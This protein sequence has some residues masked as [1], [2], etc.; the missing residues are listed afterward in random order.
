LPYYENVFLVRPDVSSQQ[1][2]TLAQSFSDLLASKGGAVAKVEHWGLRNLT[3]RIK[4]NRKAHYVLLGID[5]PPGAI[6]ELENTLRMSE[7]VLRSLTVRV[8]ALEEGP[9]AMMR[10]KSRDDRPRRDRRGRGPGERDVKPA[11]EAV[12]TKAPDDP[13]EASGTADTDAGKPAEAKG[14]AE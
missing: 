11:A 10:N 2:E 3:Y 12:E 4:K 13:G 8:D 1:V 5:S 6:R 14:D 9:S 7:D